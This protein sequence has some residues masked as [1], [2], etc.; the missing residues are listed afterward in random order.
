[1]RDP[2]LREHRRAE[3]QVGV[4]VIISLVALVWGIIFLS[5]A[6]LRGGFHVYGV[7]PDAGQI[8]GGARIYLM[9]VD[10]GSVRE[11]R[12][13]GRRVVLTL[14]IEYEGTLPEDTRGEIV[15]SGFLGNQMIQL[16]PGSAEGPL[17][18]GD[19]I[20]LERIPDLQ[21]LVGDLGNQATSVLEDAGNLL[22]EETAEELRASSGSLASAMDE[23]R[24]MIAD[25]RETLDGLLANLNATSGSLA[26]ATGEGRLERTFARLDT[27]TGQLSRAGTG[28]DSTSH[29]LASL[30]TKMDEGTGTLGKLAQDEELYNQLTAAM[31]NLQ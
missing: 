22:S 28:L 9:G 15:P 4:L 31:E 24:E 26:A 3:L 16:V 23:L 29:A 5:D 14:A 7:T 1:M 25:Q 18:V 21:A 13:D 19:T 8:T 27:L 12:L 20:D 30:L 11:V 10:V 2:G 17:V 6:D